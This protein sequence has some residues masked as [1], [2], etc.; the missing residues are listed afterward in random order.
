MPW[1]ADRQ[2]A[3]AGRRRRRGHRACDRRALDASDRARSRS[4]SPRG[5]RRPI[6]RP[7]IPRRPELG[8]RVAESPWTT[9][10]AAH[11][12]PRDP[13]RRSLSS[14]RSAVERELRGDRDRLAGPAQAPSS[15]H[16]RRRRPRDLEADQRRARLA[17]RPGAADALRRRAAPAGGS[18]H[19]SGRVVAVGRRSDP[20]SATTRPSTVRSRGAPGPVPGAG[21]D[22]HGGRTRP[23]LVRGVSRRSRSSRR[24]GGSCSRTASPPSKRSR[25]R[26]K[27]AC[28]PVAWSAP[29]E[30]RRRARGRA[31]PRPWR[32]PGRAP[33]RARS[34]TAHTS[35]SPG[36]GK[37]PS[38]SRAT[39]RTAAPWRH[40]SSSARAI[41]G[42]E[43]QAL[44]DARVRGGVPSGTPWPAGLGPD[45]NDG[46]AGLER[47][48]GP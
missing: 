43:L 28:S 13:G 26:S 25:P 27:R 47:P 32:L 20:D 24:S 33:G 12:T 17:E 9:D 36:P 37:R 41:T 29:P 30:P 45:E 7:E 31:R 1:I 5:S 38:G 10:A 8:G 15:G 42:A 48:G 2:P 4:C 3:L 40:S 16:R 11:P 6:C 44:E 18:L 34:A 39:A 21:R 35:A 23:P 46:S 22:A 19:G 14:P